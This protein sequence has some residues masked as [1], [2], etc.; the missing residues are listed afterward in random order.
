MQS[1]AASSVEA[2]RLGLLSGDINLNEHIDSVQAHF[3]SAEPKVL[4]FIRE[5]NRFKRIRKQVKSLLRKHPSVKS[6]PP[7]FGM[8]FGVKDIF[9]VEGFRTLAGSQVP[10]RAL[11]GSQAIS[12]TQLRE[13]GALVM[14]KT[15]TTEF[16]YFS[17][18][19]TRNPH[20][21]EHTP[22][23]SSSGSAA[24]VAAGLVPIALG[25][26]T[27]GSVI[28][29]A[30]FCGTV[31]FKPS[32]DRISRDGVIP[33]SP[34][35]DHVGVFAPNVQTVS[36]AASVLCSGWRT[37][38]TANT[39]PRLAIPEGSYLSKA[40]PEMQEHF[41]SVVSRLKQ[42]GFTVISIKSMPDFDEVVSRHNLILRAEAAEVH[43]EWYRLHNQRYHTRTAELIEQGMRI[44]YDELIK[45]IK[46]AKYFSQS[47][48]TQM[49]MH[50]IDLWMAP[51]AI[52]PAPHGLDKTGDPIMNLPW[53]QAGLPALGLPTGKASNGLPLGTQFIADSF[54]DEKL[55]AWGIEIEQIFK[56]QE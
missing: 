47:L 41:F 36:T 11:A 16:A 37:D 44:R 29:P 19:P 24:A 56:D 48:S 53:T 34:S 15:V 2:L 25:T 1:S 22:G 20:N 33:L 27:I 49:D 55:L 12:V 4:S 40:D 8:L 3:D 6:R 52:G 26:Q 23:G 38:T 10:W 51:S 31:G 46:E 9:H 50:G 13:A 5:R 39:R 28:R 18:G 14:G 54:N 21:A 43:E 17:P 45:A 7:L 42:A 35:L 32:Y 30:S